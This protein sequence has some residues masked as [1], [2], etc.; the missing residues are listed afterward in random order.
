MSDDAQEIARLRDELEQARAALAATERECAILHSIVDSRAH[1]GN[2]GG[3]TRKVEIGSRERMEMLEH[4]VDVLDAFAH[5]IAD[6][7]CYGCD[8]TDDPGCMPCRARAALQAVSAYRY[9]GSRE[10]PSR[11][12]VGSMHNRVNDGWNPRE[13][14]IHRA[15]CKY[16]DDRGHGADRNLGMVLSDRGS[17]PFGPQIDWPSPRDW[18]VA[19]SVVQWLATNVGMSILEEAGF[20]YTLWDEDRIAYEARRGP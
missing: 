8:R 20:K 16:M 15:W 9:G 19:T 1:V 2:A 18:Y 3:G 5:G 4:T 14:K 11:R 17:G 12:F 10:T 13:T 6:F 7:D